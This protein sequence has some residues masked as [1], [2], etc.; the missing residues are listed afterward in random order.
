M[1]TV[2]GSLLV[3]YIIYF[4]TLD[5]LDISRYAV[6]SVFPR[7]VSL[8]YFIYSS[9]AVARESDFL[10]RE[11]GFESPTAVSNCENKLHPTLLQF[12][13]LYK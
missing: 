1:S 12:T 4:Y 10:Q 5:T 3:L 2:I 8:L 6:C 11:P 13:Q 7:V 9:G